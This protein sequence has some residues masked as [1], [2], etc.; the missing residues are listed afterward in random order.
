MEKEGTQTELGQSK[1]K[2]FILQEKRITNEA[3][4]RSLSSELTKLDKRIEHFDY[5]IKKLNITLA[6]ERDKTVELDKERAAKSEDTFARV[7][8]I[9]ENIDAIKEEAKRLEVSRHF[10]VEKV[11]E[12]DL[13]VHEWEDQ[14][15]AI[16]ETQEHL[17][18]ERGRDGEMEGMKSEVHFLDQRMKD[19]GRQTGELIASL[20]EHAV[21]RAFNPQTLVG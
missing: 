15:K 16:K 18:N 8:E 7:T 6:E 11:R 19:L 5:S 2:L 4:I 1:N 10:I 21:R 14:V 3:D 17:S 12:V 13:E 20:E 9:E